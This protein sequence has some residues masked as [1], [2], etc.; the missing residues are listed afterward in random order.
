MV[1]TIFTGVRGIRVLDF[2]PDE[3]KSFFPGLQG[4]PGR[5]CADHFGKKPI[6]G[7]QF[8]YGLSFTFST[9]GKKSFARISEGVI[10]AL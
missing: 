5:C 9:S 1:E 2:L 10:L 4:V 3:L 6:P 8:I 7:P